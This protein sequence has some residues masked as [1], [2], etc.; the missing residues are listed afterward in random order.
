MIFRQLYEPESST[1]TY[2]VGDVASSRA[3][4]IDPVLETVERDLE[5]LAQLG[6]ELAF[7]L[8]THVH[9]DHLTG[10]RAL[11][12]RT[13]CRIAGPAMDGF[14][15]VDVGVGE[16]APLVVGQLTLQPLH[17]PGH[18]ATHHCYYLEHGGIGRV[19]TGDTLLIDGCGR[20]DFQSGDTDA[21]FHSV[22]DK[23]F[24]LPADTLVYPGHDYQG[25]RVSSIAQERARNPRLKED[26]DLEAFR[27]IM[28][29][30]RLPYPKKMDYAVPG[31]LECGRC[32]D[33]LVAR[34]R[35]LCELSVQGTPTDRPT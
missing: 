6:L 34:M 19:F 31:N 11:R 25:R 16:D 32:P 4:L 29:Q 5:V 14:A 27:D 17:T 13:G 10:A 9:A 3:V 15:C 22:R 35:D 7:T 8:E 28:A 2:L 20:T 26:V 24:R 21:L 33:H 30:L 23:L 1:Y 18:T 12:E